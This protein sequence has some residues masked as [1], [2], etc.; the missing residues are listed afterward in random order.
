MGHPESLLHRD[1]HAQ[2]LMQALH[3][4]RQSLSHAQSP[5][6]HASMHMFCLELHKPSQ[7]AP[8]P[9]RPCSAIAGSSC[10]ASDSCCAEPHAS[11][12]TTAD[13]EASQVW[14]DV[15]FNIIFQS[16]RPHEQSNAGRSDSCLGDLG[17]GGMPSTSYMTSEPACC[18]KIRLEWC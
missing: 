1:G 11:C 12:R 13:R 14:V 18:R 5:I 3:S 16:F 7:V 6:A 4:E 10:A 17:V 2:P 9:E 8:Q 15:G